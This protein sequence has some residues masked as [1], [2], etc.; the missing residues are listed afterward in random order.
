MRR[1][2]KAFATGMTN[3]VY[4]TPKFFVSLAYL[5]SN[6][7]NLL[8]S[9]ILRKSALLLWCQDFGDQLG[10]PNPFRQSE[11][12]FACSNIVNILQIINKNFP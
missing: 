3:K 1:F 9:Y 12:S 2:Y 6:P 8:K 7:L 5:V 11:P 4:P 10:L